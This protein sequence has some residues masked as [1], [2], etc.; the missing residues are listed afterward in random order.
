MLDTSLSVWILLT[1]FKECWVLFWQANKLF[2][3]QIVPFQT[4]FQTLS[5]SASLQCRDWQNRFVQFQA[6]N[7][8]GSV[9]LN[10]SIQLCK[11]MHVIVLQ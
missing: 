6:V 4:S 7:I 11:Q 9:N 8:L 2:E 1:Y 5:A 3:Y 10:Y